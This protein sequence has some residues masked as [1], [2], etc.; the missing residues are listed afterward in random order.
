MLEFLR[1]RIVNSENSR[2]GGQSS[3]LHRKSSANSSSRTINTYTT[4]NK[5]GYTFGGKTNINRMVL[6]D[7]SQSLTASAQK[8]PKGSVFKYSY[9]RGGERM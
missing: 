3:Q 5:Q 1:F 8:M 7:E 6:K 9:A 4:K 2:L